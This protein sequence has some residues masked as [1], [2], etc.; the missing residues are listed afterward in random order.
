MVP[1]IEVARLI[2]TA[3]AAIGIGLLRQ[4][5]FIKAVHRITRAFWLG[6]ISPERPGAASQDAEPL[7]I[8]IMHIGAL[9]ED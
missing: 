7:C 3:L 6:Y 5:L 1:S 2:V 8:M 4:R 9:D